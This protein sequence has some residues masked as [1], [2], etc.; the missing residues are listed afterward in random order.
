MKETVTFDDRVYY[1]ER[2]TVK[3]VRPIK[4]WCILSQPGYLTQIMGTHDT[5]DKAWEHCKEDP[6]KVRAP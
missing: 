2:A 6:F 3:G 4:W 1:V 5:Y